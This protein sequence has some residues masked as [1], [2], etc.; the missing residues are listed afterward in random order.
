MLE[1]PGSDIKKHIPV[2]PIE[3][4]P[5]LGKRLG[6]SRVKVHLVYPIAFVDLK[7]GFEL[8]Q[9]VVVQ[10]EDFTFHTTPDV[11]DC[12]VFE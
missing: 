6:N 9:L 10:L 3:F 2:S 8:K 12:F 11:F 7:G 5:G 4:L 1:H